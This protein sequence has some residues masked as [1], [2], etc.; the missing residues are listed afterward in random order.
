[1]FLSM[2]ENFQVNANSVLMN[3]AEK[4]AETT[5]VVFLL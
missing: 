4:H 1:M 3:N 5:D 2:T